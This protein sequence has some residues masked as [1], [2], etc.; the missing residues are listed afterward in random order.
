MTHRILFAGLVH[1]T[2]SFV[3]DITPL[4]EF[5]IERGAEL[6]AHQGD[7]SAMDGFLEVASA[8]GWQI[9]PASNFVA[10]ASG[11]VEHAVFELFWT[12][13]EAALTTAL[14]EGID[15]IWMNLHGAMVTTASMDPEGELLARIRAL[16]GAAELPLFASFDLHAN[17]TP[18]MAAHATGLVGYRENPHIDARDTAVRAAQLL[19]RSLNTGVVPQMSVRN[20]PVMWPPTGTGTADR[21][22]HDLEALARRLEAEN[23]EIWAINV[24]G[25]YSFSDVPYAGV[26]F[27]AI[28]TAPETA[29]GALHQLEDMAIALRELGLPEEWPL[30]DALLDAKGRQGGPYVIV[31]AADNIG[32]GAPGD[33][34]SVL[35]GL[36][37][38]GIGNAAVIIAD[39]EAVRALADARP[40]ER[41]R[42]SVGGKGS[43]LDPG[44]LEIEASFVSRS[45]GEFVLEDRNSHL[46]AL[47]GIHISMGPS[48]V[49][50]TNGIKVLL[51]S[52]KT[53]PFDLGQLRSQG[54]VPET[55]AIIGVKAAVAHRRAYDRIAKGSYT[56][57]TP[58]PCTSAITT[59]PYRNLRSGVF[60]LS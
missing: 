44:P 26:A 33:C 28:S 38:H 22:M 18:L 8:E 17:F 49:V 13:L 40:G 25:G 48:A 30:D 9:V 45:D 6:L 23:P 36:L 56:V 3:D 39:A 1:E 59:L 12:E 52:L 2:H 24:V 14:R 55:L 10:M 16:P 35:R 27:S 34:T 51:T 21:P 41:R 31:E 20:A 58:G 29:E 57:T 37:R 15:G 7:G 19:A 50:E 11:P 46:A 43:R 4:A 32:G 5:T 54:I 60:P 53:P 42:L 47:R